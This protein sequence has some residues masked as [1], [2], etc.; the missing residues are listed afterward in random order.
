MWTK[1]RCLA[2]LDQR[3]GDKFTVEV[4]FRKPIAL[5]STVTFAEKPVVGGVR[6]AVRSAST[7]TPHLDGKLRSG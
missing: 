3:L 2:A 7:G 4:S 5:P 1:A 6:F